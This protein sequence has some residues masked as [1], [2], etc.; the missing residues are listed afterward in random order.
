[1]KKL[2]ALIMLFATTASLAHADNT[3]NI[4]IKISGA[5]RD[6]SYFLCMPDMGCLSILAAKKG[7][8]YTMVNQI[9]MNTLFI[10]DTSD[11]SVHNQGLPAT[12]NVVVKPTQTITIYGDLKKNGDKVTVNQLRCVVS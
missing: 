3:A 1:M 10:T 2:L 6:N 12:C 4:K 8:I 9:D 11:M 5:V 7:K